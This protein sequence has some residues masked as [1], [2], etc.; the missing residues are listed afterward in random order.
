MANVKD[1]EQNSE[2]FVSL[3]FNYLFKLAIKTSK[4][5]TK[6]LI[7]LSFG[8][9]NVSL[10]KNVSYLII[11]NNT[12]ILQYGNT[13]TKISIYCV[14]QP[15]SYPDVSFSC[16]PHRYSISRSF[17]SRYWYISVNRP[18]SSPNNFVSLTT[19]V[20]EHLCSHSQFS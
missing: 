7:S 5:W 11:S 16:M 6:I 20:T 12:K 18:T 14:I 8:S 17:V 9:I 3:H 1:N 4:P 10:A 15:I 13:W 2:I 19:G